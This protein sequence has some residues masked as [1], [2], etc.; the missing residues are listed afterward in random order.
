M[1]GS[2]MEAGAGVDA[3]AGA[4]VPFRLGVAGLAVDV[5]ALFPET[6]RW[7]ADYAVEGEPGART[8]PGDAGPR[9]A[10]DLA[11]RIAPADIAW[12]RA[13]MPDEA[14][15]SDGYLETL[16]LLRHL[17]EAMPAH[18]RMLMHGAVV[19]YEGRGYMFCASSGTGK[20]THV[21]L[22]CRH[23]GTAVHV[24]NGDKPFVFVPPEEGA[25]PVAFGTP[26]AG[27]EGWQRNASVPL[28]GVCLLHRAQPGRSTARIVSSDEAREELRSHTY[29]PA[30]AEAEAET[31]RLLDALM[32]RT[33]L[34]SA[35]CDMSEAAVRATFEAL[36]AYVPGA[37]PS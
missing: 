15:A 11:V 32:A 34:V 22:W 9:V 17:A 7:C 3:G 33:R 20:S 26:W 28:A 29:M 36:A 14:L 30:E 5:R 8:A 6:R 21:G 37:C 27:K 10:A 13:H 4:G 24:V 2:A 12:E 23:L 16:A 19:E 31:L 25:P 1:G 35:A 18:R